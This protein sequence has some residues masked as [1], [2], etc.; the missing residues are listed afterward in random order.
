MNDHPAGSADSATDKWFGI[1]YEF[2]AWLG[3][4]GKPADD[5]KS[6][7]LYRIAVELNPDWEPGQKPEVPTLRYER[8]VTRA[9]AEAEGLVLK[10]HTT[11]AP[12]AR[13]VFRARRGMS[14]APRPVARRT[15]KR[16]TATSSARSSARRADDPDGEPPPSFL[17]DLEA[18]I[19]AAREAAEDG[20][21]DY[22]RDLLGD[23][24]RDLL[25]RARRRHRCD[26]CG[27]RFRF[28]GELDHHRF[29]AHSWRW[30][31]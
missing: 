13:S 8:E 26:E 12:S 18:R 23:L 31:A 15:R 17:P 21:F 20:D 4:W 11:P 6:Q 29:E 30:A 2:E 28:P 5:E 7:E 9:E 25:D 1:H 27:R 10:P 19:V 16:S 3:G 24:E 14:R 22:V